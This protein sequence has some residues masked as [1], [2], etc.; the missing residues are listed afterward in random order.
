LKKENDSLIK[1][2]KIINQSLATAETEIQ[3]FQSLKQ[4]KLNELDVVVPLRL[5]QIQWVENRALPADLSPS[6]VFV[7]EGLQKLKNRIKELQQVKFHDMSSYDH[8][9]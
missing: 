8:L 6:L 5:H 2:E 1:K 7:N 4:Q 9:I 3:E